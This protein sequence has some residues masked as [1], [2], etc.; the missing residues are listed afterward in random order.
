MFLVG[1]A[2]NG[3]GEVPD[4][5]RVLVVD[6]ETATLDLAP[7]QSGS[8]QFFLTSSN[9]PIGGQ[10]VSF[11]IVDPDMAEGATLGSPSTVTNASGAAAVVVHAGLKTQF[12]VRARSLTAEAQAVII[13]AVGAD[14]LVRPVPF[15]GPS[16]LHAKSSVA[17]TVR[18]LDGWACRDIIPARPP[19][20]VRKDLE[21]PAMGGPT[22]KPFTAVNVNESS[23]IVA[24]ALGTHGGAVAAGCVDVA[25]ASLLAD[26]VVDVAVR[27][28]DVVPNP[29]GSDPG[30]PG[31]FEVT[32]TFEPTPPLPAAVALA[33][34]WRNLADCPLDPAQLLLDCTIDALSAP[35]PG[36]PLDCVPAT[37]PGAETALG[38]ALTARRSA[39]IS[40]VAGGGSNC[41]GTW[42]DSPRNTVLGIDAIVLG[43]YGSPLKPAIA[44]LP[45]V[46][47]EAAHLLDS[48]SLASTFEVEL[49][50]A[51]SNFLIAHR[52]RTI[53]FGPPTRL[54][55]V[56]LGPLGLPVLEART[57]ATTR[58][59]QLMIDRHGFTM[60][61]GTVA[62][63]AFEKI[64][65]RY[66]D[67]T[68]D[69]V[70]LAGLIAFQAHSDDNTAAGCEAIDRALCP[71]VG[72]ATG[73][74][75][76][77]CDAGVL[78][79]GA[80]LARTF[81]AL[82]GAGLDLQLAGSALPI[83]T[84]GG[85]LAIQLLGTWTAEFQTNLGRA[86][87]TESFEGS[88]RTER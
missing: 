87:V 58:D 51:P 24:R 36:D 38:D 30:T 29:T 43:L 3:T 74:L 41:R 22:N 21:A 49:G 40:D 57:T 13:V 78:A 18:L 76:A 42:F 20:A 31:F 19:E 37:A 7:G 72:A 69:A 27:L 60:R 53:M 48:F 8:V 4:G 50:V 33:A 54:D 44:A 66:Y 35:S 5:R 45:A 81:D 55:E 2:G 56:E 6:P 61:L 62:K 82:D 67:V 17:I 46:A 80:R 15:F 16:S 88:R 73:C 39:F 59:D 52:L 83:D 86:Q 77:A 11:S 32:S 84:Q 12:K 9:V 70:S 85:G 65:S 26:G 1:C 71:R 34:E 25:G 63:S 28:D 23:A 14:G 79:L 68:G 75:K 47:E 64:T 10:T